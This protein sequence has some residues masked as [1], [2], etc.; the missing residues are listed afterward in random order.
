MHA[1]CLLKSLL[2]RMALPCYIDSSAKVSIWNS[3]SPHRITSTKNGVKFPVA[4]SPLKL[5]KWRLKR[6]LKMYEYSA[7]LVTYYE[8]SHFFFSNYDNR[9]LGE[10]KYREF[11]II[12]DKQGLPWVESITRS[13]NWFDSQEELLWEKLRW[14]GLG[15]VSSSGR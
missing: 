10:D 6:P 13:L 14:A 7:S 11:G 1:F 3:M 12:I 9:D 15:Q 5:E 4:I 2:S 8:I